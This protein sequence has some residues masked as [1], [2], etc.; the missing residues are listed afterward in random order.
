MSALRATQARIAAFARL[1]EGEATQS[2]GYPGWKPD[3]D[4]EL[5]AI[6]KRVHAATLGKEAEIHAIHAGLEC[7]LIGEK[8]PGIDMISIGPQ[9]EH[10]H[11]PDERVR[12]PSV[13]D[14]WKLLVATLDELSS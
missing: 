8:L 2:E 1:A 11:S 9:I 3:M 14:Y 10:P 7:G 12:V 13:A 5:L 4:S 6:L